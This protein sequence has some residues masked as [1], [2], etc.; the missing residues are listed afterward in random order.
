M[1]RN[2]LLKSTFKIYD[3]DR[4]GTLN[5]KEF[6]NLLK[7]FAKQIT[8]ADESIYDP[9][10]T[11][12]DTSMKG[13]LTFDQIIYWWQ[14]E[15][16]SLKIRLLSEKTAKLL[17]KAYTIFT[18]FSEDKRLS[19]VQFSLMGTYLNLTCSR[20]DFIMADSDID[21]YLNFKEFVAW[22]GWID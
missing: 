13:E 8:I 3:L 2:Y 14:G 6:T 17:V 18:L 9:I 12:L 15:N 7:R 16:E 19:Y 22:L 4:S 21:G 10:F 1:D 20:G 11:L 5:K